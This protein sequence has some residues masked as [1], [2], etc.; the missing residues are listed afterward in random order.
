MDQTLDRM[1][2]K[3]LKL[4]VTFAKLY[5]IQIQNLIIKCKI[6]IYLSENVCK[7]F[8][9]EHVSLRG[10]VSGLFQKKAAHL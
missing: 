4:V 3:D 9:S 6:I 10:P 8:V 2:C 7:I 1:V 5:F